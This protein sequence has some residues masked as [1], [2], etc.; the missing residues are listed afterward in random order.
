MARKWAVFRRH[1]LLAETR[2]DSRRTTSGYDIVEWF[3]RVLFL[4]TGKGTN[5]GDLSNIH[6]T[7]CITLHNY[8]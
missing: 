6:L 2:Q 7:L 4:S 1:P 3:Y 8:T 5:T